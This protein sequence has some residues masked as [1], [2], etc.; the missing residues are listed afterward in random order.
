MSQLKLNCDIPISNMHV[1]LYMYAGLI[2]IVF[3]KGTTKH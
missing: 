2:Q 1:I 3:K